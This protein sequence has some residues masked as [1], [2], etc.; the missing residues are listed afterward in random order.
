MGDKWVE[1]HLRQLLLTAAH[2]YLY[3]SVR[4]FVIFIAKPQPQIP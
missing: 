1:R 2:N 3:H 4:C